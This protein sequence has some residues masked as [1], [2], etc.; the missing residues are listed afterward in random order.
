MEW[1]KGS[2]SL[3]SSCFV[4]KNHSNIVFNLFQPHCLC[5]H[6]IFKSLST[7]KYF[8]R[9]RINEEGD[10]FFHDFCKPIQL[11]LTPFYNFSNFTRE[12][13]KVLKDIPNFVSSLLYFVP[14][15]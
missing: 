10:L 14:I 3:N 7:G 11:I 9:F 12:I 8:L 13:N 2:D 4:K 15:F 6:D 1:R 5:M